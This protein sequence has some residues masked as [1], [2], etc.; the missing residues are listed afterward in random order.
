[1]WEYG[2]KG[3]MQTPKALWKSNYFIYFPTCVKNNLK[4]EDGKYVLGLK[5]DLCLLVN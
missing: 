5:C 3:A 1:M 2:V 4:K